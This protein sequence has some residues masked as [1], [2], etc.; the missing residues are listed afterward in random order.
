VQSVEVVCLYNS[1]SFFSSVEA[2]T[3]NT[4]VILYFFYLFAFS[5]PTAMPYT[6]PEEF[7]D[8][9]DARLLSDDSIEFQMDLSAPHSAL[10]D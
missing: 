9:D 10:Y 5:P 4:L 6:D 3:K 2:V 1:S 8:I 7:I